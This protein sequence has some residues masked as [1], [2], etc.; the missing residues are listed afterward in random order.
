MMY[1]TTCEGILNGS[2]GCCV[3]VHSYQWEKIL[4]SNQW[5]EK[6]FY[7]TIEKINILS[8]KLTLLAKSKMA[9]NVVAEQPNSK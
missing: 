2:I 5:E 4:S 6:Y 3:C 9:T 7:F 8:S 1:D